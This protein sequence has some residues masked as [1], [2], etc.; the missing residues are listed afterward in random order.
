MKVISLGWG[1]Q[2]FTLAAMAVLGELG[3]VDYAIHSDTTFESRLTYQFRERWETWLNERGVKVV[4]VKAGVMPDPTNCRGGVAIPAYVNYHKPGLHRQCTY[5][6]K[7][8]PMRQWLQA[9]R[10]GEKIELLLGISLD[11]FKRMKG[12]DV[13]YITHNHSTAEWR[14]IRA[15]AEDW[16]LAVTVDRAVRKGRPPYDLFVHPDRK[17][18]DQVDF[19]TAEEKGQLSLWDNECTGICGI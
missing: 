3:P 2:S 13:Q 5:E 6:W 16:Q 18:L 12:S 7:I 10:A 9:N 14:Q 4:T 8:R 15:V 19:R 1:V 11:E 17:P